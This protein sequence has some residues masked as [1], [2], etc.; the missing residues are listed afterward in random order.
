MTAYL[1]GMVLAA[2]WLAQQLATPAT[3]HRRLG[4]AMLALVS[5]LGLTVTVLMHH[6]DWCSRCCCASPEARDRPTGRRC[7]A[8]PDVP[9]ARWR[10][11]AEAVDGQ[12][13]RLAAEEA[14]APVLAAST[15]WIPGELGVYCAGHP[16]AYSIGLTSG[17]RHSQYD[18]WTNPQVNADQFL[19]RTFLVVGYVSEEAKQAFDRV[20]GPR[21]VEYRENGRLVAEWAITVCHGFRGFK[22]QPGGWWARR[23]Y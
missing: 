18:L 17:D 13:A 5:G 3:W 15:W 11:L 4:W 14:N 10:T 23:A 6:T 22:P 7:V 19:D 9:A 2:D 8:R 20:E 1:S 16:Q 12:R 21:M